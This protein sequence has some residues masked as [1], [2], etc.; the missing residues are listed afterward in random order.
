MMQLIAQWLVVAWFFVRTLRILA[1]EPPEE[2]KRYG[3][4]NAF[5]KLAVIVAIAAVIYLSGAMSRILP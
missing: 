2:I 1:K 5:V 3:R 4:T